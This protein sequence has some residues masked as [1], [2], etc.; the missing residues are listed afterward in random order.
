MHH[1]PGLLQAG[2]SS[3]YTAYVVNTMS[4]CT[5]GEGAGLCRLE[6]LPAVSHQMYKN[7]ARIALPIFHFLQGF[8][9]H[10]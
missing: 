3:S 9:A 7:T 8:S 2:L 10:P 5:P 4:G 6:F 1:P